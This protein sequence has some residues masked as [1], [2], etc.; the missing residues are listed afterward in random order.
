MNA[1]I[2]KII[3]SKVFHVIA[4]FTTWYFIILV[5]CGLY[6]HNLDSKYISMKY[7]VIGSSSGLVS[8]STGKYSSEIVNRFFVRIRYE[9]G[10]ER[11]LSFRDPFTANSYVVGNK[12]VHVFENSFIEGKSEAFRDAGIEFNVFIYIAYQM[13]VIISL[14]CLFVFGGSGLIALV[15]GYLNRGNK[16]D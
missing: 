4:F 9:N 12:Y 14:V 6:V 2:D 7:D 10:H 11:T 5:S 13:I 1:I 8:E 16:N 15:G 3:N